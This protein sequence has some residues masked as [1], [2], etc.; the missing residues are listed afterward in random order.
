MCIYIYIHKKLKKTLTDSKG[1]RMMA[2]TCHTI[3]WKYLQIPYGRSG[4]PGGRPEG[5]VLRPEEHDRGGA[6]AAHR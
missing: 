3:H 6:A 2:N 1:M 4:Q 5:E